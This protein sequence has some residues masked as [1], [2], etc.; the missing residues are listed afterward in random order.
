MARK[1]PIDSFDKY[2]KR[3]ESAG[4]EM[5]KGVERT[6]VNPTER[7]AAAVDKYA[8]GTQKAVSDGTFVR[9]CQASTL[10]DWKSATAGKGSQNYANGV[11]S[12][13]PKAKRAM[14][15]QFEKA[16]KASEE[17][18]TMANVTEDDARQRMLKNFELMKMT[19]KNRG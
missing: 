4:D 17:I 15:E 9:G 2:K 11:R 16:Q 10:E 18:Q 6:T 8:A 14:T 1:N 7:A 5:K 12:I 3:A 13:S 19:K